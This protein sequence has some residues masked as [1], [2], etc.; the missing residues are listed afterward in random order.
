MTTPPKASKFRIRRTVRPASAAAAGGQAAARPAPVDDG[1]G[2][3]PFPTSDQDALLRPNEPVDDAEIAAIKAEGL[4]GR[5]LRTARRVAQKHGIAVPDDYQAVR[6]L[7]RRGIDPFQPSA[8]L[9]LIEDGRA[10]EPE[11]IQLP[12]TVR[13]SP[14][15]PAAPAEEAQR[16]QEIMQIQRDI[17]RRR[18]RNFMLLLSRLAIFVLLPTLMAGYYYFVI[19][20]P[21]YAT[22]SEFIIQQQESQGSGL[23]SMFRGTQFATSQ[24]SIA[25]QGY[26]QSRDAM[27]RLDRDHGFKAH[28]SQGF[29][30][31][32]QRLDTGASNEAAYKLYQRNV[33]IGYD[34][35]EGLIKMEVIA[36]DPMVSEEFSKA[37]IGYAEEQ[38]DQLS[39]RLR[40]DQMKGARDSYT[41]AEAKM[42][43]AQK[44]VLELQETLG[45]LDPRTESSA[46]M[47]QV[48]TFEVE[49]QKKR[50][51]LQQL[52]DN[53][54]PNQA[55]VDG[56]KGDISRLEE[57]IAGLRSQLTENTGTTASL[58]QVTGQLRIA[59]ADLETRQLMLAQ[60]LQQLETARIEANR[61]VRYLAPSVSPVA[62]DEPTYPRAFENT[63]L[64]FL[65]FG[66]IYLMLSL[67]A[68]ILREQATS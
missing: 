46:I 33:K 56:T 63:L 37:L 41:D 42:T 29:I 4:S 11:K 60:A 24:D 36:A 15:L 44:R 26:L 14:N 51:E 52:L 10:P 48:A 32:I 6:I 5:Q 54:R 30:D 21:F 45:V 1:F 62:P 28:F 9:Q 38:V 22:K 59:E 18:R 64:A 8:I 13:Q 40:E 58:A 39:S 66:G 43:A 25:V 2:D 57:L 12:Q 53:A 19:A 31:P 23:G 47:N 27:L 34:P 65:I 35:T 49:L 61:Q 55:R 3:E 68:S 50:L 16:A 20:T 67:T 17:V 7:R